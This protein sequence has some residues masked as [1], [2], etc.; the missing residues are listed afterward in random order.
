VLTDFDRGREGLATLGKAFDL[1][2]ES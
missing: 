2:T 1:P